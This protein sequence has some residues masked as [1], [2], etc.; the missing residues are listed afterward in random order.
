MGTN[1]EIQL[2]KAEI[3]QPLKRFPGSSVSCLFVSCLIGS[4]HNPQLVDARKGIRSPKTA[5]IPM[6]GQTACLMLT[7]P[8]V[9]ELRNSFVECHQRLVVYPPWS[10]CPVQP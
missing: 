10:K 4:F 2:P 3:Q 1:A 8:L 7:A 6:D 9:I 5:S